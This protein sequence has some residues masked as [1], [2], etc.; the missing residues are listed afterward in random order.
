MGYAHTLS[1]GHPVLDFV[2]SIDDWTVAGARDYLEEFGDARQFAE[3]VGL[4]SRNEARLLERA[5]AAASARELSFLKRLRASLERI[6]RASLDKRTTSG[7]DLAMLRQGLVEAA[8]R[9]ELLPGADGSVSR[10]I[11]AEASGPSTLRLRIVESARALL[12]SDSVRQVKACPTCGWFFLDVSKNHSRVWCSM[13]TC[14]ARAKARRYYRRTKR[15]Q[16]N[17][18]VHS[19]ADTKRRH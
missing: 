16:A 2:N 6:L 4:I 8:R 19:A 10:R 1:G 7:E 17:A 3:A 12:S 14:G 9:T 5:P 15:A 13:D 18:R 11:S